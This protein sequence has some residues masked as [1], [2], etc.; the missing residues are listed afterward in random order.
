MNY[1]S[2]HTRH[3]CTT[4]KHSHNNSINRCKVT[5][6]EGAYRHRLGCDANVTDALCMR[7]R[8][9]RVCVC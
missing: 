8:A 6:N 5:S 4:G 3:T 2:I 1:A 7:V 9:R